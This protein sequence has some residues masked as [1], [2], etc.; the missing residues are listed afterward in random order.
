MVLTDNRKL[1]GE[2][3][4]MYKPVCGVDDKIYSNKCKADCAKVKIKCE[5]R[6]PCSKQLQKTNRNQPK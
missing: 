3:V 4:P 6:C 1:I 5:G 2:M